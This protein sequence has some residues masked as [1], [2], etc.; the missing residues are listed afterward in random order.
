MKRW[1]KLLAGLLL[2]F[3]AI[4]MLAGCSLLPEKV[5]TSWED[6]KTKAF[7]EQRQIT[8]DH[9]YLVIEA[10]YA[11][12]A[13]VECEINGNDQSVLMTTSYASMGYSCKDGV[14]TDLVAQ[15]E[16]TEEKDIQKAKAFIESFVETIR[17]PSGA[18]EVREFYVKQNT[19]EDDDTYTEH[20]RMTDGTMMEYTFD[21][22]GELT[23]IVSKLADSSSSKRYPVKTIR[24]QR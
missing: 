20:I 17:I 19:E 10:S 7:F 3:A 12:K 18:D 6:S 24:R 22:N 11:G 1:N 23:D 14:Y 21:A 2:A 16:L 5:P 4:T 15:K 13:T 8:E 9:I